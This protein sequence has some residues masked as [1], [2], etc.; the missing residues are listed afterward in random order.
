M[1]KKTVFISST[2]KD[3]REHR[4]AVWDT[5]KKFDVSV[6]GMEEFGA[7]TTGALD[8]CLA[9]VEE[10]DVYVGVIGYRLGSIDPES[11]KPYTVLEYE[12]AVEQGAEILIY[13][14]DD[15]AASF[16]QSVVDQDSRSRKRLQA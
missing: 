8:T 14:A 10:S 15:E 7:R 11:R 4:R 1:P 9:E 6:R 12:K 13:L 16:P 2:F 5:L 3:L